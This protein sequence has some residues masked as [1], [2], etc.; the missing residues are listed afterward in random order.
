MLK[1]YMHGYLMHLRLYSKL[2]DK[3]D[4]INIQD[5]RKKIVEDEVVKDLPKRI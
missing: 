4:A 3:L 2:K 5:K 1:E